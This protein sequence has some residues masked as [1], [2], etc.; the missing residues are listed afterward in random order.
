MRKPDEIAFYAALRRR[1]VCPGALAILEELGKL[2]MTEKRACG[3]LEKWTERGWWEYG[4]TFDG[5][6]F[7][8]TA[9][10]ELSA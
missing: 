4:V 1:G 7:T 6:W 2:G 10:E 8:A 5:G 9:P 3:L